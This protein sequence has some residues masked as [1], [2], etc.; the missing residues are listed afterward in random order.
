MLQQFLGFACL[1]QAGVYHGVDTQGI[2]VPAHSVAYTIPGAG[3]V[4]DGAKPVHAGLKEGFAMQGR[5][6]L[7]I[8]VLALK[9]IA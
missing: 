9:G 3:L 8:F 2:D 1:D 4:L 7:C 6:E 5:P